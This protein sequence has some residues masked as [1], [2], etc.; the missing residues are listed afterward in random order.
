MQK[1]IDDSES[2]DKHLWVFNRSVIERKTQF[3]K[4]LELRSLQETK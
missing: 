1:I 4:G 2:G 3:Q